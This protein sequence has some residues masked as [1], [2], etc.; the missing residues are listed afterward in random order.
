[1]DLVEKGIY[2]EGLGG[3]IPFVAISAKEGTG[4]NDLLDMIILVS[5]MQTFQI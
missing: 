2:L 5:D 4:V 3:D 1:M